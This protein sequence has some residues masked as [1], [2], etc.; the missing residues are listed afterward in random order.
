MKK[1]YLIIFDGPM[2][3]IIEAENGQDFRTCKK[4]L[5]RHINEQ[6]KDWK[7]LKQDISAMKERGVVLKGYW[8]S[9]QDRWVCR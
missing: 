3:T 7:S 9:F 6:I 8:D 5:L 4:E 2:S 1:R